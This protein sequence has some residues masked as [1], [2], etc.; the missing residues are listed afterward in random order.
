MGNNF[1]RQSPEFK[2]QRFRWLDQV[3]VDPE[4]PAS[5]FKVAYRIG[6]DFNDVQQDGRAWEG[7]KEIARAIGMSEK[8]VIT[9]VRRLNARGH[10]RVEW[11][12]QGRGHPNNYWM[13][14]KP[15][16]AQVSDEIKPAS[17]P[18]KTCAHAGEPRESNHEGTPIGVPHGERA[19]T[20]APPA[21]VAVLG[22]P[23]R[24]QGRK[25]GDAAPPPAAEEFNTLR[26]MWDRGHAVDATSRQQQADA[27][28]WAA[29]VAGAAAPEAILAAAKEWIGAADAPR[30]LP[31]LSDWLTT[32]SWDKPPPKKGSRRHKAN[33]SRRSSS[34]GFNA[35]DA[36]LDMA[37]RKMGR[38]Q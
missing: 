3:L 20:A 30:F 2:K 12:K 10:L 18:N 23:P 29:A 1:S 4:L 34:N 24:R 37:F 21:G 33:G 36:V 16:S 7:C 5:A 38:M 28:A 25:D 13:I 26:K 27:A 11:G 14:L 8:T 31:K 9:M 6:D 35:K 17:T 32:N 19:A 15:A 22:P